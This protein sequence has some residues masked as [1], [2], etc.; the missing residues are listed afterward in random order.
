MGIIGVKVESR[1][2]WRVIKSPLSMLP[3]DVDEEKLDE[4]SKFVQTSY[5]RTFSSVI[6]DSTYLQ[7]NSLDRLKVQSTK[8]ANFANSVLK[9]I[10]RKQNVLLYRRRGKQTSKRVIWW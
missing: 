2:L 10:C 9:G 5:N 8:H 1:G 4:M 7:Y 3:T 6:V